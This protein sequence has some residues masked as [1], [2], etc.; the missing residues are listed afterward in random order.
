LHRFYRLEN[1]VYSADKT[2][3]DYARGEVL[4]QS[5]DEEDAAEDYESSDGGMVK[6]GSVAQTDR[7]NSEVNLDE[8]DFADLDAQ[9]AA[10]AKDH[11]ED[12]RS[13]ESLRTNRL[14]VVNLD[15]DHVRAIHLYKI[16]SSLL[17]SPSSEQ[18]HPEQKELAVGEGAVAGG[19]ILS[20]RIHLSQFGKERLTQEEKEGP[21]KE[22][23]KKRNA[24]G[25][26]EKNLYEIADENDYD[27]DALRQYQLERLRCEVYY[28]PARH[29]H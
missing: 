21:P 5:S 15:W 8:N 26:D 13:R 2:I 16:C 1:E 12:A 14:A 17:L 22:L 23:F 10:Y 9:A 20:V 29:P 24:G 3:T 4:L 27:E 7:D 19:R 11:P 28:I 25:E 18:S 6:L